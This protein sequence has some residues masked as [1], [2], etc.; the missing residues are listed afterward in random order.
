M[1]DR[2]VKCYRCSE[3]AVVRVRYAKLNL[4]KRHFLEYIESRVLNTMK[5][6]KLVTR[7]DKV[8]IGVSGG[9]DSLSLLYILSSLG[10]A[11][12]LGDLYAV[13]INLGLGLF[14]TES[15]QAVER[16]CKETMAR[17]IFI[18]L[19]DIIGLSLPELVRVTRRPPCSLCGLIKR[20]LINAIGLELGVSK[21]ALGHHMDDIL[22]FAF[23]DLIVGDLENLAK[24]TPYTPGVTGVVVP[25]IK[26]LYEIYEDD[27]ALYAKLRG[28]MH[29]EKPCP[30]KHH[31]LLK[32]KVR[33]AIDEIE[34]TI[35][36]FKITLIR[37]MNKLAN[38]LT[39][40]KVEEIVPCKYC[41][42]PSRT[43]VCSICKITLKTHGEPRGPIIR[44]KIRD[45]AK[46]TFV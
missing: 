31:D 8:L 43:G 27:L 14:S 10:E 42:L 16:A 35:P 46:K 36:G 18:N 21:A 5:R 38:L 12:G 13:H 29:V 25:R 28:I 7:D 4:C 19:K 17:C 15:I 24:M 23:K 34:N 11:I 9:K 30:F 41:G 2:E 33:Q 6:Y 37:R 40:K 39:S 44:E 1:I 22:V 20:Y 45:I 26:V 32:T 3:R